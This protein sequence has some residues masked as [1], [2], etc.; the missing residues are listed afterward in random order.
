MTFEASFKIEGLEDAM[1]A[2]QA[3]FPKD[4]RKQRS[5]LNQGLSGAARVTIIPA[6]KSFANQGDG[7]GALAESIRP[8]ARSAANALLSGAVASVAIA[9]VRYSPKAL[10]LYMRH[11]YPNGAP[12]GRIVD[13]IRHGHLV[14]FGHATKGGGFVAAR[15]F[16]WPAVRFAG[17]AFNDKFA[18]ILKRKVELAVRRRAR[19]KVKL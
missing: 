3:A 7:S 14:E 2:M 11:Y 1:A 19:K 10:A 15:P 9:P 6:A 12:S 18:G 5:L 4:P 16:L 13:G 8:R 17:S